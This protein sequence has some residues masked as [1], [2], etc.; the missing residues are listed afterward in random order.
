MGRILLV[1]G[2]LLLA[3]PG[4]AQSSRDNAASLAPMAQVAALPAQLAGF[5]RG[6]VTDYATLSG[7]P[8]LGASVEYRA[9]EGAIAT[10]YIYDRGRQD[11][12]GDARLP[13]I[14]EELQIALREVNA[15]A[16]A[17]RY[18][19]VTDRAMPD[20]LDGPNRTRF[21][22][23]AL[24]LAFEDGRHLDSFICATV[25]QARFLKLR[26]SALATTPGAA[27]ARATAFGRA[28][29]AQVP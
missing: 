10:V 21:R 5:Q 15:L 14:L 11:L 8:G 2:S 20:I 9:P 17:R 7:D 4:F 29:L 19:V 25:R 12:V 27:D 22:C 18:R 1:V 16:A 6:Q 3:L 28:L 26:L 24:D 23:R 13:A